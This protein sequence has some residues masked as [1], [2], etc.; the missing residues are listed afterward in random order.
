MVSV[1]G[2]REMDV[3]PAA[4]DCFRWGERDGVRPGLNA[5]P[6]EALLMTPGPYRAPTTPSLY[7]YDDWPTMCPPGPVLFA[8]DAATLARPAITP[9]VLDHRR[10]PAYVEARLYRSV[11]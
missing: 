8:G 5:I 10:L 11:D 2:T 3:P 4:V 1:E 9:V 6:D 7:I